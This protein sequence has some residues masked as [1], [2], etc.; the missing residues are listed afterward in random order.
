MELGIVWFD[1]VPVWKNNRSLSE[2]E[3]LSLKIKRLRP[4][5]TLYEENEK[6]IFKWRDKELKRYIENPE[7]T[8]QIKGMPLEVLKLIK[9]FSGHTKDFKNFLFDGDEKTDPIDV[10]LNI[11][12]PTSDSQD[13]SLIMEIISVLSETAHLT[14]EELKN[15]V[16]R[17]DGSNL[18][19]K[20]DA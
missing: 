5:D 10:F 19:T 12:N 18:E 8:D 11:P 15:Y 17:P 7:Y 13:N 16:A 3:Q 1:Y 9:R 2:E 6:D 4:I 14:G 20:E